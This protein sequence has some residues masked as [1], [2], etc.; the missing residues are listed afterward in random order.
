MPNGTKKSLN[1]V[2]IMAITSKSI[3]TKTAILERSGFLCSVQGMQEMHITGAGYY[4]YCT[5]DHKWLEQ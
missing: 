3:R 4:V 1:Y 5:V 2:S